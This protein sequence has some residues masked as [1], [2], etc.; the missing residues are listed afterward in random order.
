[1]VVSRC[2]QS[3][4]DAPIGLELREAPAGGY[5]ASPRLVSRRTQD[6]GWPGRSRSTL[7]GLPLDPCSRDKGSEWLGGRRDG[8]S[9]GLSVL[10]HDRRGDLNCLSK[11]L[12]AN[13]WAAGLDVLEGLGRV[14]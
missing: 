6:L 10:G 3:H 1:M 13:L 9:A 7:E 5:L 4:P 11:D 2:G 14:G 12:P 8:L